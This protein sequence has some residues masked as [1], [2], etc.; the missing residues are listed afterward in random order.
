MSDVLS[1][2]YGTAN[3]DGQLESV[4]IMDSIDPVAIIE[5]E[6]ENER[7]SSVRVGPVDQELGPLDQATVC[8]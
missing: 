6:E 7:Q 3:K 5:V 4:R 8:I 2:Q 1:S